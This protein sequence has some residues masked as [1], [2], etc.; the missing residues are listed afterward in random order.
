MFFIKS[1]GQPDLTRPSFEQGDVPPGDS[2]QTPSN[3]SYCKIL[4]ILYLYTYVSVFMY[5]YCSTQMR[6]YMYT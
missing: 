1:P 3:F 5:I 2:F 6:I 4:Q